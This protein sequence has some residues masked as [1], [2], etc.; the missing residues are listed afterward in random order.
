MD[1]KLKQLIK[2]AKEEDWDK[3]DQEIPKIASSQPYIDWAK[4]KGIKD[5]DGNV[6]DFAVSILEKS[7]LNPKEFKDIEDNLYNL[8]ETDENPYVKYR[9][10]F[11]LVSHGS[12]KDKEK[13]LGVLRSAQR[14]PDTKDIAEN[15]L[16]KIK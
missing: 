16:E 3:I 11:A 10:A 13:L 5:E 15:Y 9:S 12:L 1:A 2:L 7:E 6:R 8:M 14:D 4:E